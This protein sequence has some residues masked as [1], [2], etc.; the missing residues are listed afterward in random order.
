MCEKEIINY[1]SRNPRYS[2]H[3]RNLIVIVSISS[4][5]IKIERFNYIK[6]KNIRFFEN[7]TL[8]AL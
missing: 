3:S 6:I 5:T 2:V 7:T 1:C 8:M 4:Q